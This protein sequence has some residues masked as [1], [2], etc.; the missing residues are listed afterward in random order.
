MGNEIALIG[1]QVSIIA[2]FILVLSNRSVVWI[3]IIL[4]VIGTILVLNGITRT[5]TPSDERG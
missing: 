4:I 3:P 5:D 2:L 1:N